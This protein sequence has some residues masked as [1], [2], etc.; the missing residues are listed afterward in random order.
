MSKNQ[1]SDQEIFRVIKKIS[2]EITQACA[3]V[4]AQHMPSPIPMHQVNDIV[5]NSLSFSI[6]NLIFQLNDKMGQQIKDIIDY[7]ETFDF[8][9]LTLQQHF[10]ELVK[11]KQL[12]EGT[13]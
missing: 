4:F 1:L 9:I 11:K 2:P 13:H 7:K 6:I 8:F 5:F 10:P 3:D 12:H